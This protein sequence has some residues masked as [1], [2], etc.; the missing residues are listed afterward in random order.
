MHEALRIYAAFS[1]FPR[2]RRGGVFSTWGPMV[3]V[4]HRYILCQIEW[5]SDGSLSRP[6]F[7]NNKLV[8]CIKASVEC[9]FGSYAIGCMTLNQSFSIKYFNAVT[10]MFIVKIARQYCNT[11]WGA[12][13]FVTS[14][15]GGRFCK[16]N[17]VAVSGTIRSCQRELLRYSRAIIQKIFASSPKEQQHLS[18]VLACTEAEIKGLKQ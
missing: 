3:R 8:E 2:G 6:D 7:T 14:M 5:H 15:D 9:N 12:L 4:K 17:V 1:A 10:G 16:L 18:S 13:T 11:L